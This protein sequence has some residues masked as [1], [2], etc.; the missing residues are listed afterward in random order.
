MD[1]LLLSGL[2]LPNTIW[3]DTAE[4]LRAK[5]HRVTA[6]PLPGA[7]TDAAAT[8]AEQLAAV[9]SA[10]DVSTNPMIVGH[11]GAATLAW[12]AADARPDAVR[13]VVFLGGM[14]ATDGAAYADFFPT[15]A[16]GM[17]FPGW[18]PFAGPDSDDLSEAQR[19]YLESVARPVPTGVSQATVTYTNEAR[20]QVTNAMLCPEYSP[21]DA[22]AWIDAGDIPELTGLETRLV[23]LDT[24]HWPMTS[25]PDVLADAIDALARGLEQM[26]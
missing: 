25:A 8:L 1:I 17:P 22:Q 21:E 12:L 9:V 7:D 26:D 11:S 6:V 20:K 10:V 2:W 5:G 19:N 18:E 15:V 3:N 23:N 4:R 16:G 24:G 14:P 13:G